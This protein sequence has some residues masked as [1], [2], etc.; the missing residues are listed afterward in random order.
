VFA[1]PWESRLFGLT[2]ALHRAGR[3]AWDDFKQLLIAEIR[4]W[5]EHHAPDQ[6]WSYYGCWQRALE[7]LLATA[8]LCTPAELVARSETLAARPAGHDH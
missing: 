6:E 7:R 1:A 4:A 2:L 8:G 3:F 5:E